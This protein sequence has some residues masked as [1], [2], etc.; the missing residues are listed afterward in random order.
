MK[1]ETFNMV[2]FANG[3]LHQQRNLGITKSEVTINISDSG[4]EHYEVFTSRGKRFIQYE[5]THT[6]GKVF[7]MIGYT[8]DECRDCKNSWIE[9][10]CEL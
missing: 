9:G 10:G 8:L 5:Y 2:D 6:N 4:K 7:H 3:V 1:N